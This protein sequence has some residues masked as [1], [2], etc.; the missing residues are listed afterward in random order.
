MQNIISIK[1]NNEHTVRLSD[2]KSFVPVF[3]CILKK[4]LYSKI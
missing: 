3:Y 1:I 4:N 2:F